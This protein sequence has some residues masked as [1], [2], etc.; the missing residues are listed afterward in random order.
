MFFQNTQLKNELERLQSQHNETLNKQEKL[1]SDY[2]RLREHDTHQKSQLDAQMNLVTQLQSQVK[3]LQEQL[4][5]HERVALSNTSGMLPNIVF[6][7][8]CIKN[9]AGG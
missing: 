9:C 6:K 5:R 4:E 8:Y 1:S 7:S 2:T 3:Q